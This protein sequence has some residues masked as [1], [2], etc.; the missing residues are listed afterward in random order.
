MEGI[1]GCCRRLLNFKESLENLNKTYMCVQA[2]ICEIRGRDGE[3]ERE[4]TTVQLYNIWVDGEERED[5]LEY[6]E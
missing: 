5:K 3:R 2:G 4:E 6:S 1:G